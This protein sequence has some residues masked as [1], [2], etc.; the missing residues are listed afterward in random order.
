VE[1]VQPDADPFTSM[2]DNPAYFEAVA[3]VDGQE[4]PGG[5]VTWDWDFGDQTAHSTN[6]PTTHVFTETGEYNVTV[7]GSYGGQEAQDTAIAVVE[8]AEPSPA[9]ESISIYVAHDGTWLNY[10]IPE[11]EEAEV[12]DFVAVFTPPEQI[13]DDPEVWAAH[14][15][16]DP[17]IPAGWLFFEAA[18]PMELHVLIRDTGNRLGEVVVTDRYTEDLVGT[19]D[20]DALGSEI[21]GRLSVNPTAEA[22]DLNVKDTEGATLILAAADKAEV[23]DAVAGMHVY[24]WEANSGDEHAGCPVEREAPWGNPA[25]ATGKESLP[26][27]GPPAARTACCGRNE[28]NND[29]ASAGEERPQYQLHDKDRLRDEAKLPGDLQ[30]EA[31][32]AVQAK[33]D[34]AQALFPVG[35]PFIHQ[36]YEVP[37]FS[38]GVVHFP[39]SVDGRVAAVV[40]VAY[41]SKTATKF[42]IGPLIQAQISQAAAAG[43]NSPNPS[44]SWAAGIT[45]TPTQVKQWRVV[46]A[47][48]S[49]GN[50]WGLYAGNATAVLEGINGITSPVTLELTTDI[51]GGPA[52]GTGTVTLGPA[53]TEKSPP[54]VMG[55][56]ELPLDFGANGQCVVDLAK[57]YKWTAK[58]GP[59]MY[60]DEDT[61][62]FNAPPTGTVT[63]QCHLQVLITL[64]VKTTDPDNQPAEAHV[65]V[66]QQDGANWILHSNG[67]TVEVA[68]EQ[69][70][71][72]SIPLWPGTYKIRAQAK[73]GPNPPWVEGPLFAVTPAVELIKSIQV[74]PGQMEPPP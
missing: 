63:L 70:F 9:T 2:V 13:T 36:P 52:S 37:P 25:D 10:R 49:A 17:Q 1:I 34:A 33:I 4:L 69:V 32:D 53:W 42:V 72:D 54:G 61:V 3:Y 50:V 66:Y 74:D 68:G 35:G 12:E 5:E 55:Q 64:R 44:E 39:A 71:I 23:N 51:P 7:T 47:G 43:G 20:A 67:D 24:M 57:G 38:Q 26:E 31:G 30:P 8:E 56:T 41:R 62:E 46:G 58:G 15:I 48:R 18:S 40:Y 59:M 45:F 22:F 6:N 14:Q 11:Y 28:F 65:E 27:P 16:N 19:L 73:F 21:D 29:K 60:Y